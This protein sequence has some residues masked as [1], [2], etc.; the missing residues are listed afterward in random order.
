MIAV[1]AIVGVALLFTK[2]LD[3]QKRLDAAQGVSPIPA[4]TAM[5]RPVEV[6]HNMNRIQ[7]YVHKLWWAG[8]AGNLPLA[9]FYRH[10]IKEEMEEVA[11][12]G[13]VEKGIPISAHMQVYGIRAIDVLKDQLA[14]DSLKDFEPRFAALIDACNACH[15]SSGHA[16]LRMR[17]PDNN[18]FSEQVFT[19]DTK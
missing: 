5:P 16:E 11:A 9:S 13:I 6:A 8:K 18:R 10:E 1:A 4:P 19:N 17:V 2:V 14:N 12:A 7:N 3:L 15:Q